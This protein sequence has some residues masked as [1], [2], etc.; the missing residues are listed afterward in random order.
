L[1]TELSKRAT[2]VD[3]HVAELVKEGYARTEEEA[4]NTLVYLTAAG[5]AAVNAEFPEGAASAPGAEQGE[6]APE[7]V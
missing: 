4:G 5:Y 2:W 7:P 1:A 3:D 6:P